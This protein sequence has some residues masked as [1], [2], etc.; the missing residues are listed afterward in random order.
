MTTLDEIGSMNKTL[1]DVHAFVTSKVD[2]ITGELK[3]AK[4]EVDRMAA[5]ILALQEHQVAARKAAVMS[6]VDGGAEEAMRV[7][8]GHKYAGMDL[9]DLRIMEGIASSQQRGGSSN[10]EAVRWERDVKEARGQLLAQADAG[11]VS[12]YIIEGSRSAQRGYASQRI[13]REVGLPVQLNMDN[14]V[15]RALDSTTAAAGDELVPTLEARELWM[16]VNLLTLVQAAIPTIPMPSN[17]FDVPLQLGDTNWYPTG[18]NVAATETTPVTAKTTLNAYELVGFIAFSWS[19]EEDAVIA[20]LP[21]IRTNMVRNAAEVLDDVVINADTTELNNIN[22]DGTT[23]TKSTA[24]KAQWL[25]GYDG[26]RHLPLL[27]NTS[28]G[29][30]HNN[31]VSDDMFNEVRSLL[32]KYGARPSELFWA[33]DVKTFIRSQ[34]ISHFR[35]LDKLGVNATVLTGMLGQVEGI[36]VLVSEQ[37]ALADTDGLVTD[38][39]NAEDNGSLLIVNR[40]QWRQGFR[41]DFTIDTDRNISKRQTEIVLS[42]R[43]ALIERTG[44]RGSATHTAMQFNITFP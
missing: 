2:D 7:P 25:L 32:G 26:L 6:G 35:T 37:I 36:P 15:L 11:L 28:Q 38:S 42:F 17:P 34:S 10:P 43:H 29:N 14:A 44:A 16:D 9:I 24:G 22:A 12:R 33:M 13:Y 4:E 39:G 27:D 3:L 31:I 8:A 5:D 30:D 1:N 41:R 20:L 18:E 21:E 40:T 23:I 19:L